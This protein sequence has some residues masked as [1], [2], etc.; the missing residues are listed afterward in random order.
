[1]RATRGSSRLVLAGDPAFDPPRW[2]S[3]PPNTAGL[4]EFAAAT[5]RLRSAL[6]TLALQD[7]RR[8]QR[9]ISP[10]SSQ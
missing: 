8:R 9:L 3:E 6:G 2:R 10:K 4:P 5:V 7:Y 1:M